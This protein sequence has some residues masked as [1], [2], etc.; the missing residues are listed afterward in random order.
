MIMTDPE[1]P[2]SIRSRGDMLAALMAAEGK[3]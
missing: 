3:S 2:A 1:T